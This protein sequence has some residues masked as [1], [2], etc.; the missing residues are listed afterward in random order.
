[1]G[2]TGDAVNVIQIHPTLRCNLRCEHCYSTSGPERRGALD[3]DRLEDFLAEAR[4]EGF[5]AIGL[6]GG[7]PLLYPP[8]SRLVAH[9]RR[10]GFAA[11]VTTNGIA[12]TQHKIELLAPHV[13]LI[14]ISLDGVPQSHDR[15]RALPGAFAKMRTRLQ[16][17]REAQ[18]PFG[19]IFTLTLHNL[20][21]LPWVAQFAADEGA[22]LLQIHPL[23]RAGRARDLE[24]EP[25]DDLELAY[26]FLEVAKLQEQHK[27]L[28]FQLDVAD[29][30]LIARE[31]CRAF[32]VPTPEAAIVA[33]LPLAALVSP[34]VVQEDGS[35]V[36]VQH[37]FS[38]AF[39]IGHVNNG[40]FR[41]QAARW[42]RECYG[43]FLELARTVW[44]DIARA[45]EHLPFTN[46]YNAI[47]VRS[48]AHFRSSASAAS[49]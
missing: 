23:E 9:A 7:E 11:T 6:S 37:G 43:P 46:W 8:L 20:H 13:T 44:S 49:A 34:L 1:M 35:I 30:C 18:V 31:P 15:I 5:N 29:R 2:P 41:S 17:L 28:K 32:A 27:T 4:G 45:P 36:P 40:D 10:L 25:P 12:L 39:A 48:D 19:F 26:A 14:A 16:G 33:A 3:I 42:K 38:R 22:G 24:F 21:E 47:T